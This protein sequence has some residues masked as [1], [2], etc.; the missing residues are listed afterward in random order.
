MGTN[1]GVKDTVTGSPAALD[2]PCSISG[3]CRCP[4]PTPY[5][6]MEPMTSAANQVDLGCLAGTGGTGGGDNHDVV[7]QEEIVGE[8]GRQ[9]EQGRRR[10]AAGNGDAR[11]TLERFTLA[12]EFRE[13]VGPRARMGGTVELFPGRGVLQAVVSTG[14]DHYSALR[15]LRSYLGRGAVRQGQEHHVM[16]GQVLH[17]GV[18]QNPAGQTVEMRLQLP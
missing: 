11:G 3:V 17:R 6:L 12:R 7:R 16:A 9:G 4:P 5:G 1:V 15:Q 18:F 13:A 10:V 2:S 8:A 14:V